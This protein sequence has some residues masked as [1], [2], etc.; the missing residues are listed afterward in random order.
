M[1][2]HHDLK[3]KIRDRMAKTG[4]SYTT[5][6]GHI[7][8]D[9]SPSGERRDLATG[10]QQVARCQTAFVDQGLDKGHRALVPKRRSSR[11]GRRDDARRSG[12]GGSPPGAAD[13]EARHGRYAI[14]AATRAPSDASAASSVL[15]ISSSV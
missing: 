6:R 15:A 13:G 2:T 3:K 11:S 12:P 4:E 10:R 1:P 9:R 14:P 7:L 8:G 5:A